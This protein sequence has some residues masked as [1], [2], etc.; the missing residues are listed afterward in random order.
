MRTWTRF[1]ILGLVLAALL[2]VPLLAL[3]YQGGADELGASAFRLSGPPPTA[4]T[5]PPAMASAGASPPARSPAAGVRYGF[6]E[7]LGDSVHSLEGRL[8]LRARTAGGGSLTTTV[9]GAGLAVRF[10]R[11]CAKYGT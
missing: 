2:A 5:E 6:D 1:R 9:H 7:G 4:L 3:A 11:P 10:P 8:S